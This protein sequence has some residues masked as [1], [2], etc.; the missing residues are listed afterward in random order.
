MSISIIIVSYNSSEEVGILLKSILTVARIKVEIIIVDNNSRDILRLKHIIKQYKPKLQIKLVCRRQNYGFANSC[1]YAVKISSNNYLLFINPDT[2]VLANS[3]EVLMEHMRTSKSDIIGGKVY[4]TGTSELHRT[5]FNSL[6]ISHMIFEL[7]SI[8][9][10]IKYPF[11]FYIDHETNQDTVVGGV[12][13][14]YMLVTK[15]VFKDLGGFDNG[16][17]MYLEDVD[18]CMRASNANYKITYC[19]HSAISHIGGASSKN[20]YRIN[21]KAWI[22]SRSHFR[23]KHYGKSRLNSYMLGL[24]YDIEELILKMRDVFIR[25]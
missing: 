10:I 4:K 23:L 13:A 6:S 11:S 8:G 7:S 20:K 17:F 5:A 12:S 19:P 9:K 24:I 14:A 15:R 1:N 2:T 3:L 18:F 25:V 22:D 21:K 16:F